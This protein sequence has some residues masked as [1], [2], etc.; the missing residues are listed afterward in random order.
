MCISFFLYLRP[1]ILQFN[2]IFFYTYKWL[3]NHMINFEPTMQ[4]LCKDIQLSL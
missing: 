1:W 4:G 2:N 3:S